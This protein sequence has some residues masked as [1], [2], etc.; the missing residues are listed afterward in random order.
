MKARAFTTLITCL[1]V[2]SATAQAD[3]TDIREWLVP[4]PKTSPG[5]IY[6]DKGSRVWFISE[7]GHYVANLTPETNEFNRYDL[8]KG[9]APTA[10]LIDD[11]R[12]LWFASSKRKYIGS[13]NPATGRISEYP[14]PDKKAKDPYALAFDPNGDIWFTTHNSNYL[15]R[16]SPSSETFDLIEIPN[17]KL[18]LRDI[19]VTADNTPW[20]IAADDNK[21][22]R[23][24]R[25]NM[26]VT[27]FESPRAK[28]DFRQLATTT[29]GNL[30]FTDFEFGMLIRYVPQS[31]TFDEWLLPGGP[32]S[33]PNG[34]AIDKDDR[35]WLVETG[36][37]P[38]RLIGFDSGTQTFLT[39]TAIP[40]G[41]ESVSHLHYFEPA[42]EMWFGTKTN[43]V[44]RAKVH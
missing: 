10:L 9:T 39:E 36:Q 5:H 21:I 18:R 4:W 11:N 37:I 29:D 19:V 34:M 28:S 31:G 30:W 3:T 8:P 35:I 12:I 7:R 2:L 44:G 14:L 32:K 27:E 6:I 13:L 16:L 24:N 40:S 43:Y 25:D 42:G 22:F 20:A 17:R 1:I 26:S 23:V 33:E 41:A 15:G 38:N